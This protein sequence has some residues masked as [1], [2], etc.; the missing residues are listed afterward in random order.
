[1]SAEERQLNAQ[2]RRR[3]E[4]AR[5]ARSRGG[6]ER[7]KALG[8]GAA[9]GLTLDWA[10]ELYAAMAAPF[11]D[12]S[13]EE[14]R[15]TIRANMERTTENYPVETFA[16]MFAGGAPTGGLATGGLGYLALGSRAPAMIAGGAGTGAIAGAGI[17]EEM[18]DI[19]QEAALGATLGAATGIAAPAAVAGFRQL[20]KGFTSLVKR[21][22]PNVTDDFA[23]KLVTEAFENSGYSPDEL[24]ARAREFGPETVLADIGGEETQQLLRTALN[25][26]GMR[27]TVLRQLRG[28]QR[29]AG[30]QMIR[31]LRKGLG[32]SEDVPQT[33]SA[34]L[35]ARRKTASDLYDQAYAV[36][37]EMSRDLR[38]LMNRPAVQ[39]AYREARTNAANQGRKFPEI[40]LED[41]LGNLTLNTE[42]VPDFQSLDFIKRRLD[43]Q[44]RRIGRNMELGR[45]SEEYAAIRDLRNEFRDYLK[46][47]N[48]P[49]REALESYASDSAMLE[50]M[51]MGRDVFNPNV[52]PRDVQATLADLSTGEQAAYRMG[53]VDAFEKRMLNM[54]ENLDAARDFYVPANQMKMDILMGDEAAERF[55]GRVRGIQEQRQTLTTAQGGSPTS[56]GETTERMLGEGLSAMQAARTQGL[57]PAAVRIVEKVFQRRPDIPKEVRQRLAQHLMAG[58]RDQVFATLRQYER[59][60]TNRQA[61][62][63]WARNVTRALV[64][65]FTPSILDRQ[66]R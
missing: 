23:R 15:D 37:V 1:M 64:G 53:V 66:T 33:E 9:R 24:V 11:S 16:G 39:T 19:P 22:N 55:A 32:I 57:A 60:N 44:V 36:P 62:D 58:N 38:R 25:A 5:G 61:A 51:D 41:E 48:A 21:A 27:G 35:Q 13:Y 10:D 12:R 18:E 17:A 50:A 14:L 40:F 54:R 42:I 28:R 3:Q 65:G 49:Y 56:R 2:V 52:L 29:S 34:M 63:R 46:E 6:V 31:D 20:V 26:P 45:G 43:A 7:L 59:Q 47:I 30:D 4:M 8:V